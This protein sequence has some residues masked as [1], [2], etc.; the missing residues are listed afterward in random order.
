MVGVPEKL[1][2][3][4]GVLYGSVTEHDGA[5]LTEEVNNK[6]CFT[7]DFRTGVQL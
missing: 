2:K 3:R 4:K 5:V 6:V 7:R 1:R